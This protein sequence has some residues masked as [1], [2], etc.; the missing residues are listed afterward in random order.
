LN[1][2]GPLF[3]L[4]TAAAFPALASRSE[5]Q[6]RCSYSDSDRANN[7]KR[8]WADFEFST[9]RRGGPMYYN[10]RQCFRQ[11]V[12][13]S[14]DWLSQKP[15][16]AERQRAIPRFHM[17]RNSAWAGDRKGAALYAEMAF[18]SDQAAEAPLDWNTYVRGFHAYLVGDAGQLA[19]SHAKLVKRGG[20]ANL[21]NAGVL[22]RCKKCITEPYLIVTSASRCVAAPIE[23]VQS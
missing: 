1:K 22:A 4:V 8:D 10:S 20:E 11:A 21:I 3:A 14:A 6:L 7:T 16:L 23:F 12:Q 5:T 15:P 13:A 2:A 18:R 19:V 9:E 17:A